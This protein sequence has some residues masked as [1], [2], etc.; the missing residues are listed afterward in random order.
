M[1]QREN[2][3]INVFPTC[4]DDH[5]FI[6]TGEQKI[7]VSVY[8]QLG[9]CIHSLRPL[10]GTVTVSMGGFPSGIYLVKAGNDVTVKVFKR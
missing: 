3:S 4:F 10:S 7:A 8:N 6:Q 5:L 9:T 1:N 2:N